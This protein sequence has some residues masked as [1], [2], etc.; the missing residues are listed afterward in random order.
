M[1]DPGYAIVTDNLSRRFGAKCALDGVSAHIPTGSIYGL[2]GPNGAGKTTFIRCLL[3][4]I[5]LTGGNASVLGLDVVRDTVAVKKKVGHVAALQPL[6]EGMKVKELEKFFAGCYGHWDSAAVAGIL[7]RVEIDPNSRLH[8]LSRGQ[9]TLVLLAL[10]IGHQ[11]E[12]LLLDEAL[13]GL[14]PIIRREVLRSVIEGM[15]STQ[16]TVLITGQDIADME[17]ICDYVGFLVKGRLA[18]ESPLEEL[19]GKIKRLRLTHEANCPPP[20]PPAARLVEQSGREIIFITCDFNQALIA[21]LSAP[22]VELEVEDLS[23]EEIFIELAQS[24]RGNQ[25]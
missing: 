5:D 25:S 21:N 10:A 6:W 2:M 12:V 20:L 23:L 1:I 17:R 8:S 22:G 24:E 3:N 15:H 7:N 14:D 9:R 16:R 19:K 4:M 18:L 13:T 11:P